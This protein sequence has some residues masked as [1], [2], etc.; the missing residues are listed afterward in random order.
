MV[1]YDIQEGRMTLDHFRPTTQQPQS[2][3]DYTRTNL[4]VF[5][6]DIHPMDQIELHK[7]TGEMVYSTLADKRLL[8]HRLQNSLHNIAAQLELEKAS[9]LAKDNRIKSFEEI[10]IE[11]GHDPT[12]PK[13]V[14]ALIKKKDKDIAALRKQLKLPPSRH[15]QTAEIIQKSSEEE[16]MDLVLKMNEQLKET[17]KEL[18]NMI[19]SR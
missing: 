16:L 13:G 7:Q 15:P 3:A 10:I 5:A 18:D 14:Q 19:Q 8:A 6:K 2:T 9:S 11:L 17:E 12:D 1:A 4:E